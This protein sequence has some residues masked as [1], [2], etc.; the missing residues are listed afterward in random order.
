M[1]SST[2]TTTTTSQ[3]NDPLSQ[4]RREMNEVWIQQKRLQEEL[5]IVKSKGKVLNICLER[6]LE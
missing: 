3:T 1:S 6:K 5:K 2:T 4:I